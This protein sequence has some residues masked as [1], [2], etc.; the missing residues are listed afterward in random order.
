LTPQSLFTVIAPVTAGRE[1]ELR[2]LLASMNAS[3][4]WADPRNALVPFGDF[5][6]LHFARLVVLVDSTLADVQAYGLPPPRLPVYLAFIGDCDGPAPACLADLARRAGDGLRAIFAHCEGFQ[7]ELLAWMRSRDQRPA[8]C[9][10]N[11]VGRTVLQIREEAALQQL[12]SAQVNRTPLMSI[13]EA[14]QRR[15]GLRHYAQSQIAAGRLR[16]TSASPTPLGWWLAKVFNA[17][18]MVLAGVVA[19]P[20]LIA[21]LP[22]L[23]IRLRTLETTDPEI[24]PPPD[25]QALLELQ[26]L[27]D[28]DVTNQYTALGSVKPGLFRRWLMTVVLTA[29]QFTCRHI[30]TRGYLA[31]VQTIHFARWLYLDQKTRMLFTSNYDGG[32][33]NYMDDFINKVAWGLN[34]V[35]SNG[36]GWPQTAWL[37]RRGARREHRFK[38]FQRRHQI[39]TQVWY[40]AYPGLTLIDLERNARI[41]AGLERNRMSDREALA[42]LQLL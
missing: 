11:W 23:A 9:Y 39:P 10:T 27:E 29:I 7:G 19:L 4:G 16:L 14:Q 5:P 1:R 6:Q 28:Y 33:Q 20:F 42:W 37:I 30:F 8:A 2:E 40:K 21:L 32:H 31:R 15:R 22:F 12:L 38:Y 3:P 17:I 26:Q 41:R 36:I 24:C 25:P 18:G 13:A 34:L 35:F